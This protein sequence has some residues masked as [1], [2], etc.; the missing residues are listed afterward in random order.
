V[1]AGSAIKKAVP[2]CNNAAA[3][4]RSAA[5]PATY[6]KKVIVRAPLAVPM[7]AP[8]RHKATTGQGAITP[9]DSN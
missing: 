4:L 5:D 8:G 7:V 6:R 1:V 3:L 9:S 2:A